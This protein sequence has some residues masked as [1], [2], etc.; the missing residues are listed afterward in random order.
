MPNKRIRKKKNKK[1]SYCYRGVL[2]EV[3]CGYAHPRMKRQKVCVHVPRVEYYLPSTAGVR[4]IIDRDLNYL[5]GLETV[6]VWQVDKILE[7][8]TNGNN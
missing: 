2:I 8:I 7:K 1:Y 4:A 3:N 5:A 6:D